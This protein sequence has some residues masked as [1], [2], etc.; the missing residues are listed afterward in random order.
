[1]MRMA[2]QLNKLTLCKTF[3]FNILPR[4]T[5]ANSFLAYRSLPGQ[6]ISSGKIL[7]LIL[8]LSYNH[9]FAGTTGKLAGKVRDDSTGEPLVGVNLVLTGTD[10]GAAT[11]EDGAYFVLQIPPGTYDL[12]A[13]M[14]GYQEVIVKNVRIKIDLTTNIDINLSPGVVG[15]EEI[16]VISERPMIQPDITYSQAN[17]GSDEI[18]AL[19]VEELEEVI[20]LQAGV[21]VGSDGTM[22]VRGGRGGEIVYLIDGI[23]VTDPFTSGMAVELEN[24]A[25]QELQFISG[26]FNAE[27]G[28][29]MSG[30]VN[31]VT[32]D[33]S[34]NRYQSNLQMN[35]GDYWSSDD[36]IFM[37]I[38]KIEPTSLRDW[39]GS[40]SGPTPLTGKKSSFF[41][42]GRYFFD[43]GYLYGQRRYWPDS[44]IQ[45]PVTTTW[46]LVKAGD[47][48]F[49]PMNWVEQ[50][51]GQLK[52]SL[53]LGTRSK[54]SANITGSNTQFQ[55]YNHKFKYNPEGDYQRF[56]TNSSIIAKYEQSLSPAT[57]FTLNYSLTT[58][59]YRYYVYE[60]PL[61][62]THY[63]VDPRIFS[64]A[65]GYNFYIGGFRMGHYDRESQIQTYKADLLSQLTN[66]HQLKLGIEF[67]SS[68]FQETSFTILYNEDTD[69]IPQLPKENSPNFN[70]LIRTPTE[71]SVY[72]QD[73]IEFKDLIINLGIRWDYFD[74]DWKILSDPADPNYKQPLKPVNQYFDENGDGEINEDEIRPD[75]MKND[76]DRLGYWFVTSSPKSQLSPRVALAFPITD[77]GVMH[78]SYGHFFQIPAYRYLYSNPDFEVTP[79]LSTTMGNADL[80][81][82]RTTQYE[83]GFQQ[84]IG[85]NTVIDVTAYYKDIRNLLGTKIVD[86]FI[87][88][89]RYALYVNRDYGNVRGVTISLTKRSSG[90]VSGALD[91]TYSFAEGNASDPA[92]AYYDEL[93]GNEPEKQLVA[94]DWD[95]RHTLNGTLTL[96]PSQSSGLSL[97]LQYWSGLPYTPSLAGTRIAYENSERK[98]DQYNVDLRSFWKFKFMN[99]N[100]SLNLSIYNLLDRRNE[101]LVYSDTGRATYTLIPTYTPQEQTHNTL[102]EYLVRPD[103]YSSPRQVKLGLTLSI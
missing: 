42:S 92:A 24:N 18:S 63:N 73:K 57:F 35:I 26:T 34:Y 95:Q 62:S 38:G 83:V 29:A 44:F 50:L 31:I 20:S 78:F 94:L 55:T 21:V 16:T 49:V 52:M 53:K 14:I 99:M 82:E 97:V 87:A 22:H 98:P 37:N 4:I 68:R 71:F 51:S 81:P 32:K 70:K 79:G 15:L 80:E 77:A 27:Y 40:I 61:D 60:D 9:L 75:N 67:R 64:A 43:E 56:R 86:T 19:P 33:G 46:N 96:H 88:G 39:Q 11:D 17:V 12:S 23:S 28:Q 65:S 36:N 54:I 2:T 5:F 103:F 7:F 47:E 76:T 41:A 25:I 6:I 59:R 1:M 3:R 69:Y 10:M 48:K 91:Y 100:L 90:F 8:F 85:F 101:V 58:N 13:T 74:P 102:D 45:D 66:L 89:D 93:S 72:S 30:V 84:Q